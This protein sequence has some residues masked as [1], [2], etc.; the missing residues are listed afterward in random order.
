MLVPYSALRATWRAWTIFQKTARTTA[1]SP[2]FSMDASCVREG[3]RFHPCQSPKEGAA[4]EEIK[5]GSFGSGVEEPEP[6]TSVIGSPVGLVQRLP[7]Y[8]SVQWTHRLLAHRAKYVSG[9]HGVSWA[10]LQGKRWYSPMKETGKSRGERPACKL[11]REQCFVCSNPRTRSR[12]CVRTMEET[13]PQNVSAAGLDPEPITSVCGS[14]RL[15]ECADSENCPV[16]SGPLGYWL[17]SFSPNML[18]K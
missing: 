10:G 2:V 18:V 5:P 15:Q 12:R 14:T 3:P 1:G 8:F 13:T 9:W 6:K 7:G 11:M 4:V 16:C 17:T